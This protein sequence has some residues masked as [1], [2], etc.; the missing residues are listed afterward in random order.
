MSSTK[1]GYMEKEISIAEFAKELKE[2]LNNNE[3]I[4]CCKPELLRL[5]DI[6]S[7]KI[8]DEMITVNWVK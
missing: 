2:R 4:D 3:T 7:D 5:A 6:I 1:G 8:G